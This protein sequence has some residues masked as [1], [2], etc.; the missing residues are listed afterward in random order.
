MAFIETS[1]YNLIFLEGGNVGI[2]TDNPTFRMDVQ[3]DLRAETSIGI[4]TDGSI[5]RF[6]HNTTANRVDIRNDANQ[7][8]YIDQGYIAKGDL[9]VYNGTSQVRLPKGTDNQVLSVNN[10]TDTGLIWKDAGSV[11]IGTQI[12][13]SRLTVEEIT[14][15]DGG[16]NLFNNTLSNINNIYANNIVYKEEPLIL[17]V[18]KINVTS[19]TYSRVLNWIHQGASDKVRPPKEVLLRSYLNTTCNVSSYLIDPEFNY[20]ARIVDVTRNIVMGQSSFSNSEPVINTITLTNVP[21]SNIDIELQIK[22]GLKGS[23]A[24]FDSVTIKYV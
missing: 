23:F 18:N 17:G 14:S 10:L 21:Q 2:G 3:G 5:A 4:G 7:P 13:I 15:I 1:L 12:E 8:I 24:S 6:S 20:A 22:K 19:T 16:I 9:I 11:G